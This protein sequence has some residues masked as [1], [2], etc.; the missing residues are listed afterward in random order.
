VRRV[1]SRFMRSTHE[2]RTDSSKR[3]WNDA[4]GRSRNRVRSRDDLGP[5][6]PAD[7]DGSEPPEPLTPAPAVGE[8]FCEPTGDVGAALRIV[9]SPRA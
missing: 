7:D 1:G 6:A 9:F 8:L 3:R 5:N 2:P 4:S